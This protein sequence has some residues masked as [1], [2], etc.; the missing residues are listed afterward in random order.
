MKSTAAVLLTQ[1]LEATCADLPTEVGLVPLEYWNESVFRFLLIRH[2]RAIAPDTVCWT[3][4]NR[5]DLVLPG[6][7][8]ATLWS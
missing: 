8:G 3:E 6:P 7:A 2:M 4:W 1:A 5:V